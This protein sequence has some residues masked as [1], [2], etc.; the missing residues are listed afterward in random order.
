MSLTLLLDL[1]GTLL[2]NSVKTFVPA[3]MAAVADHVASELDP[4]RFTG[5]LLAATQQMIQNQD[6]NCM[7]ADVFDA[8]FYPRLGISRE[9]LAPSLNAFFASVYPTLKHLTGKRPQAIDVVQQ[10]F[11]RGYRLAIATNPLFPLTAIEQRLEWADLSPREFPFAFIPG[12][13]NIHFAKPNPAYLAELLARMGWPD[14]P[15]IMVGDDLEN[16]IHCAQALGLPSYLVMDTAVHQDGSQKKFSSGSLDGLLSWI[17][18]TS[19]EELKPDYSSPSALLA[20]LR[21]TP[22]ALNSFSHGIEPSNWNQRPLPDEWSPTEIF[23]HLRDVE[24]EVNMPRLTKV[25][26]EKNPFIAGQDTDPWAE[27]R[28]Y[29]E[30]NGALALNEFVSSRLQV[31]DLLSNLQNED[32]QRPAR[33]AIFGPTTLQ[34]LVSIMAGHD[35]LHVHQ[36]HAII[37]PSRAH[38]LQ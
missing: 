17:D 38:N 11:K 10:A 12:I 24:N 30:Q 14:R 9:D 25:I 21:S 19:P 31:L 7:L 28:H 20:V 35:R 16:D 23:C 34:E 3:Y 29:I 1:D 18:S 15:A 8:N 36:L 6:P 37:D 13:E 33:H 32:W 27:E 5:A 22:A 2:D 4:Q 26:G